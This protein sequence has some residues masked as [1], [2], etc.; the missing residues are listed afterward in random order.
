MVYHLERCGFTVVAATADGTVQIKLFYEFTSQRKQGKSTCRGLHN[1]LY[2]Q[3][4][5]LFSD[6]PHLLKTI[7]NCIASSKRQLWAKLNF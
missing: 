2:R 4:T 5:Y 6:P 1:F 3:S 7:R